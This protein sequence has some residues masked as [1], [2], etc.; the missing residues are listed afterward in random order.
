[1][2]LGRVAYEV[3]A[4]ESGDPMPS[5]ARQTAEV[6]QTFRAVADGVLMFT[7][8]SREG[9]PVS[10]DPSMVKTESP[11]PLPGRNTT[12][13]AAGS[14]LLAPVEV[15]SLTE[16]DR[17]IIHVDGSAGLS[18]GGGEQLGLHVRARLKLDE[19]GFDVPVLVVSPGIRVTVARPG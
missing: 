14:P 7:D 12:N 13:A 17:L 18:A 1:M 10:L 9:A 19:L 4:Q 8:L 5:W 16:G 15:L 6:R 2:D 3:Y 11:G